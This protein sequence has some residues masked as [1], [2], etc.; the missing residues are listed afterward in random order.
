M[1]LKH[2]VTF[3]ILAL[4]GLFL[5]SGCAQQPTQETTEKGFLQGRV[6]IGPLC[7]VERIPPNPSCQPTEETYASRQIA[8]WTSDKKT[9]AA[10]I[11]PGPEGMY[12]MELPAGDYVVDFEKQQPFGVGG[13]NLPAAIVISPRETTKLDIIIDT[14]IR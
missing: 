7:P 8:V 12:R 3:G 5:I 10:Q 4:I 9:K 13:S 14:G 6:A 1:K 11:E 2:H